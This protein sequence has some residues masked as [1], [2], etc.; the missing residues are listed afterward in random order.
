MKKIIKK[1]HTPL[2]F[3]QPSDFFYRRALKSLDKYEYEKAVYNIKKALRK[4][5]KNLTY[6]LELAG[7]LSEI[8]HFDASN[9]LLFNILQDSREEI[10]ECYFGIGCNFFGLND[11]QKASA[12]LLK[13]IKLSPDGEFVE[14]AE[15][16]LEGIDYDLHLEEDEKDST[17]VWK[18]ALHN[19]DS[20]NAI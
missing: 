17:L 5:E 3:D 9:D 8:E 7:M 2:P 6:N 4:D 1:Q 12:S 20:K 14:D 15:I 13:Y 18:N 19:G 16:M 10:S 11:Y